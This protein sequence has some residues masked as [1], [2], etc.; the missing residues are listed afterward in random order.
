MAAHT[1]AVSTQQP[2]GRS[3]PAS[4]PHM[5]R[6][7]FASI[8]SRHLDWSTADWP[9]AHA[10]RQR[11]LQLARTSSAA[12]SMKPLRFFFLPPLA[13]A[14]LAFSAFLRCRPTSSSSS[15]SSSDSCSD[16][17][18]SSCARRGAGGVIVQ[19][20]GRGRRRW[21]RCRTGRGSGGAQVEIF[22]VL[23]GDRGQRCEPGS[24]ATV[25]GRVGRAHGRACSAPPLLPD[26]PEKMVQTSEQPAH[27]IPLLLLVL[28]AA[29]AP[30]AHCARCGCS[31]GSSSDPE[32]PGSPN[33]P[34]F[35]CFRA[36][37]LS[38]PCMGLLPAAH[39]RCPWRGAP[40]HSHPTPHQPDMGLARQLQPST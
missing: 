7:G 13:L 5:L 27:L 1:A 14:G 28:L 29:G 6:R 24:G 35:A 4:I 18:S 25:V 2:A 31:T 34:E 23:S 30:T 33:R 19:G 10:S 32:L 3:Q 39:A 26:D 11:Q 22:R 36:R 20:S 17:S 37:Q 15:S 8:N 12:S 16:T 21:R 38:H 9:A 40:P